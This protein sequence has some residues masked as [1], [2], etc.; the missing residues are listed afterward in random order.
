MQFGKKKL[1]S[2]TC[3]YIFIIIIIIIV[4]IILLNWKCKAGVILADTLQALMAPNSSI[5][6]M[7]ALTDC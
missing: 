5:S 4:V 3:G 2:N 1:H 7:G 6:C